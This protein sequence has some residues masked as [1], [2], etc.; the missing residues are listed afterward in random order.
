MCAVS[1]HDGEYVLSACLIVQSICCVHNA[2]ARIDPKHP[3][4]RR[5]HAAMDRVAQL[6]SFIHVFCTDTQDLGVGRRILRNRDLI[7]TLREHGSVVIA[8]QN[9]YMNLEIRK[10]GF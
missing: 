2:C 7:Y 6:R 9:L 10:I 1:H 5:I 3:H 4:A 8:V